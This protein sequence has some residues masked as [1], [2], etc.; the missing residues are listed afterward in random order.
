[1]SLPPER[2][3][4]LLIPDLGGWPEWL[5]YPGIVV[6]ML[7]CVGL[8]SASGKLWGG[9]VLAAILLALG[10][11]TP[12]YATLA[13]F[14]PGMS[15]LRVPARWL[16][17]SG[18]GLA[19]LSSIGLDQLISDSQDPIRRKNRARICAALSTFVA[20]L[21]V[22]LVILQVDAKLQAASIGSAVLAVA[23]ALSLAAFAPGAVQSRRQ[24][25]VILLLVTADPFWVDTSLIE[26]LPMRTE[27]ER[28]LATTSWAE[29]A[30]NVRRTF[31]PSYSVL[32][33]L[34][35]LQGRALADG[36]SPMQL[37]TFWRYMADATGFEADKYS[38]T[39]PPYPD[40][41]PSAPWNVTVD[42]DALG[43]LAVTHV[44]SS[45]PIRGTG[46]EL[47][48]LSNGLH[49]Y[50]ISNPRPYAWVAENPD[51]P[52]GTWHAPT[53]L[54]RTPNVIS[55]S[56]EGPG[57]VVFS[58][59]LYPGWRATLDGVPARIEPVAGLLR[60][61]R[62][63]AGSHEIILR[64][65]PTTVYA[66]AAITLLSLASMAVLWRRW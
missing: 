60:G 14:V 38:V 10:S 55:A 53:R 45:Y 30:G 62:L 43:L 24:T 12:L 3:L 58:E 66:G 9:F 26:R 20:L 63:G 57:T 39:L 17:V 33:E 52:R 36:V 28:A 21:A 54:I 49:L 19:M 31:S 56:A 25:F 18:L 35:A 11:N 61:V 41:D 8:T 6:L 13:S 23:C 1:M 27:I 44:V 42:G 50:E 48:S 4:G 16:F 51:D 34:G 37:V 2:L 15:A 7:A 65:R 32:Q 40:G 47:R 5:V 46:M 22:G 64:F 59:I 29:E